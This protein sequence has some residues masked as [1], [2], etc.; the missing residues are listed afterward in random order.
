MEIKKAQDKI[1]EF[2]KERGWSGDWHL[3]D[4]LLNIKYFLFFLFPNSRQIF[5]Q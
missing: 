1:E 3:K 5:F 2:D 4:L